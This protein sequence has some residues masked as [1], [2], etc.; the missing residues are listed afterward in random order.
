[1]AVTRGEKSGWGTSGGEDDLAACVPVRAHRLHF[2]IGPRSILPRASGEND[3]DDQGGGAGADQAPVSPGRREGW[4]VEWTGP[5][6]RALERLP[7]K[8]AT[9]AVQFI[10]GPLALDPGGSADRYGSS[11]KAATAP[12]RGITG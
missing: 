3:P 2:P 11:W 8:V 7:E 5:V 4:S 1:M 10:Y 9:A 6:K 12:N